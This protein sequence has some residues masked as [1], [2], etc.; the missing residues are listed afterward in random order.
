M[1]VGFCPSVERGMTLKAPCPRCKRKSR[2]YLCAKDLNRRISEEIFPYYRCPHCRLIFLYPIPENLADYYPPEYYFAPPSYGAHPTL[3]LLKTFAE[4][5][6]YKIEL[7]QRFVPTGRL[8]EIGPSWGTFSYLSKEAGFETEALEMDA[9]CCR[10]LTEVIKVRAINDTSI[11]R[12][13]QHVEPYHVIALWHAL[14]HIPD[15][16]SALRTIAKALLPGGIL[17]ISAPNPDSLQF[18]IF[19]RFWF[20]LDAPRHLELIPAALLG[21]EMNSL[22]FETLLRTSTDK[23]SIGL[24]SP[25]W[26]ASLIHLFS[27]Q[28][29]QERAQRAG[30]RICRFIRRLE[31]RNGLGS[32]YTLVLSKGRGDL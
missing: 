16:W 8:L 1:V 12:A 18:R 9:D 3:E 10:F 28:S 15:P 20:H 31:E 25:G 21:T 23:G 29:S 4:A 26:E 30:K 2:L 19:G 24:N 17:I 11:P 5:E 7:V 14:E 32:A 6:R 22:G 27:K 13:L